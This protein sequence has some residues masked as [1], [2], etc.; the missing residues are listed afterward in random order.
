MGN[1][2]EANRFRS[3]MFENR[4]NLR[5]ERPVDEASQRWWLEKFYD[6]FDLTPEG[7]A[8]RLTRS[9][10]GNKSTVYHFIDGVREAF[11]LRV[12]GD[13]P[14]T[15]EFWFVQRQLDLKG[16]AFNADG[17]AVSDGM[18]G[19]GHGSRLMGDLIDTARLI[20]VDRI[21]LRAERVGRYVWAKMGFRPTDD[22]WR[23]M[24]LEAYG[25][26]VQHMAVLQQ[27]NGIDVRELLQRIQ[28]GG[29]SMALALAA[30]E[31]PV[32][33]SEI[34]NRFEPELM[35]FG[36]V[37]FLEVASPWSGALDL[38]NAEQMKTVEAYRERK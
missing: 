14:G 12:D 4:N 29:P 20:G 24:R 10:P 11:S 9:A 36:K 2:G 28:A 8:D 27:H 6:A 35:P 15:Q 21:T 3:R 31:M 32:P 38:R 23:Q 18:H 22:A 33:S 25:F 1:V 37:F 19:I 5:F 30:M 34:L 26:I 16:S 17:M 7:M 13:F